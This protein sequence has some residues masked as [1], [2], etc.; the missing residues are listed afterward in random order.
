MDTKFQT[1]F[2]P[3]KPVIISGANVG[4]AKS[5]SLISFIGT[6][7]FIVTLVASAGVFAYKNYITNSLENKRQELAQAK[8]SLDIT[9]VKDLIALDARFNALRQLLN[10]HVAPSRFFSALESV[11]L[12]NIRF[13]TLKY[14][15]DT[16]GTKIDMTGQARSYASLAAQSDKF[17]EIK[18][19][20]STAL[21]SGL[22]VDDKGNVKF[23][24]SAMVVPQSISYKVSAETAS[25]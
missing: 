2:I 10:S 11:T 4:G 23:N 24:L 13:N 12:R 5:F 16:N 20:V 25:Q 15:T 17:A 1:S 14:T 8:S 7:I 18:E 22:D 9:L 21:F 19:K 6:F 3:K